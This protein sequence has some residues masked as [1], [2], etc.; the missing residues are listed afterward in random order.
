MPEPKQTISVQAGYVLVE[1]SEGYEV[2]AEEVPATL[3]K[4]HNACEMAGCY[5]VL[6]DGPNTRVRLSTFDMYRFGEL[7]VQLGLKLAII[8]NHDATSDDERFLENVTNNRGQP[9]RFFKSRSEAVQWLES[10]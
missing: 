2:N 5:K 4:I 1:R 8:E 9:M 6:V 3:T 7:I 10:V